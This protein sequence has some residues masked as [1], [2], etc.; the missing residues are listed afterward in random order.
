MSD[1]ADKDRL[2]EDLRSSDLWL[3]LHELAVMDEIHLRTLLRPHED[4][5]FS[6]EDIAVDQRSRLDAALGA[7]TRFETGR[8]LDLIADHDIPSAQIVNLTKLFDSQAFLRYVNAY[9]YF[10]IRFLAGRI[11]PPSWMIITPRHPPQ[12]HNN[13]QPL[14]LVK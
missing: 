11:Y 7:L 10:G 14:A 12:R 1:P 3:I 4:A 9:L 6:A 8:Q 13:E 2:L 5:G